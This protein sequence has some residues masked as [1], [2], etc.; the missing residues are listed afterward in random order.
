MVGVAL[1]G[2]KYPINVRDRDRV[3]F[4]LMTLRNLKVTFLCNKNVSAVRWVG[5][6]LT[7]AASVP[8]IVCKTAR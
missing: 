8:A 3:D 4:A 2:Y 6:V 5:G 7:S 1:V